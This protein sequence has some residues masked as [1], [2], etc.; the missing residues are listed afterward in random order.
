MGAWST[1]PRARSR[2]LTEPQ[3]RQRYSEILPAWTEEDVAGSPYAIAAY[4]VPASLGGEEGL[5][6]LRRRLDAR[7][8]RLLLDFVPNHL[9]I[10]HPW[11][12]ERP[13]LF[14]QSSESAPETFPQETSKGIR[15]LAHGKDPFFSAWTDT[16]QLDYRLP[17]TRSAMLEVLERVADLCD[18]VRCDMAMLVLNEVFNVT[19]RGFPISEPLPEH[20]FWVDSIQT[21]KRSH[22]DF[23]FLA[24]VYWGLESRLQELGFDYIYDKVLY[25]ALLARDPPTV[26]RHLLGLPPKGLAGGAHFLENHDEPRIASVLSNEDHLAA[27]LLI[28]ALPGMRFLH[29]GQL[30]GVRLKVPVQLRARPAEPAQPRIKALY[31]RLLRVLQTTSVGHGPWELL[32]PRAAWPGNPTGLDFLLVRWQSEPSEFDLVAVNLA[33]HQSQCRV[34]VQ[35]PP[36]PNHHWSVRNLLDEDSKSHSPD[37]LSSDGLLLDFPPHGAQ[38]LHFMRRAETGA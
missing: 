35:L 25:D 13:D 20:E 34:P 36:A 33:N 8:I 6:E 1:G 22:P 14:V 24:E 10:D 30:S 9:G 27:A 38:L 12:T 19:W 18:G 32:V 21:I 7:G 4:Q 29:D 37:G 5:T 17:A 16:A 23:L 31:E 15:W 2:A 11:L 3:L 28:L 26:Q